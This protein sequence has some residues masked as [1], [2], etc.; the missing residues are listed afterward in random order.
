MGWEPKRGR[1]EATTIRVDEPSAETA[2]EMMARD[3][4]M[5]ESLD[6]TLSAAESGQILEA[7]RTNCPSHGRDGAIR[8]VLER[9]PRA[10]QL[11]SCRTDRGGSWHTHVT[12]GELRS[13]E[14]S[15]P[16]MA[17]VIYG[18]LDVSIVVGYES[19]D[20]FVSGDD[21]MVMRDAFHNAIG[22]SFE[23]PEG[24]YESITSGRVD[25]VTSRSRVREA[26]SPLVSRRETGYPE[27]AQ[28]VADL[29]PAS[30]AS[31]FQ[32]SR[33]EATSDKPTGSI[34]YQQLRAFDPQ[35]FEAVAEDTEDLVGGVDISGLVISTIV[36]NVVG[37]IVNRTIWGE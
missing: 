31:P 30:F 34:G 25:P 6:E 2:D 23:S 29:T 19:A 32:S 20:V 1:M 9:F 27:M 18:A 7:G 16:D 14:N 5:R 37:E 22:E 17:N 26:L 12:P 28:R 15:L 10:V 33:D 21:D 11:S 36:G 3:D 35:S 24:L 8:G 13:P 4:I